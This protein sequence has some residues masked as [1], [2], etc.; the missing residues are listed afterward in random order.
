MNF[1]GWSNYLVADKI[2]LVV[3]LPRETNELA[4]HIK[5]SFDNLFKLKEEN[6]CLDDL[7]L[8]K[9]NNLDLNTLSVLVNSQKLVDNLVCAELSDF[10]LYWLESKDIEFSIHNEYEKD[11][12][13]EDFEKKGYTILR[14]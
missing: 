9:L 6:E 2:K 1:M 8:I 5:E 7:T 4:G 14:R 13:L 12:K 3:E 11:F 10:L